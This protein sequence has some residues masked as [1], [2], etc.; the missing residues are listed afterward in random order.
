MR[1]RQNNHHHRT[2]GIKQRGVAIITALLIVTIAATVSITI[3]TQLQLDVRRTGNLIALDQADIYALQVEKFTQ[4]KLA[5]PTDFPDLMT[6]LRELGKLEAS[7]PIENGTVEGEITD[8]NS[9][10]NLNTLINPS[11]PLPSIDPLVQARLTRL[12]NNSRNPPTPIPPSMIS[13]IIDWIDDNAD[14]TLPDGAEDGHY[15]N[16]EQAY[17]TANQPL[18]S[19][20]ELRLIKGAENLQ[21]TPRDRYTSYNNI[22][23]LAVASINSPGH[24]P[25]LCAFNT[26][27]GSPPQINV[28]TASR[29][30]LISLSPTMTAAI[31]DDI[32]ACRG[33]APNGAEFTNIT[34]FTRCSNVD[35]IIT[36]TDRGQ[37]TFSSDYFLL[38]T[39]VSLG[40]AKKITYSIIFRNPAGTSQ[41]ISR[42]QRTL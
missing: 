31:A 1:S 30:V 24:F 25:S 26:I 23:G 34:D 27:N 2:I 29:D 42:T 13:A 14:T 18:S 32:I 35:T 12:F 22:L 41:I 9:C 3:S 37:L 21:A 20:T 8:L 16:L 28:N 7:Y 33:P 38:K 15:L 5:D 36:A 4:E 40:D 17:R 6:T 10:I 19:I 11:L 39:K